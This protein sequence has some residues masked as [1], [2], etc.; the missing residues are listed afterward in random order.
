MTLKRE[1]QDEDMED[2]KQERRIGD[3]E[4]GTSSSKIYFIFLINYFLKKRKQTEQGRGV[5]G[6]GRENLKQTLR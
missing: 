6:E 1:Y 4:N 3:E 5:K 2:L